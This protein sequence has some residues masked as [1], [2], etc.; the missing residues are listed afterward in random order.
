M[1]ENI[2]N[3][4]HRRMAIDK[5]LFFVIADVGINLVEKIADA[6]PDR[7]LNVGIAEQNMIGVCAGL[8]NGGYHPVTYTISNFSTHRCLEQVRDEVGLH[9]YPIIML[10]TTT[11]F[12][13]ST[14]GPTHHAI[15]DWGAMRIVPHL[16][17][18]CPSSVPYAA[19]LFDDLVDRKVAAYVRIPKGSFPNP[20]SAEPVVHLPGAQSDVLVVTYGGLASA[21]VQAQKLDPRLALMVFNRLKPVD[22]ES[23][24]EVWSR[25][26]RIIVVEDHFAEIGLF[27]TA[28][29]VAV[30]QRLS[31]QIESRAPVRYHREVGDTPE[32]FWKKFGGDPKTLLREVFGEALAPVG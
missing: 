24:A 25:Y 8:A 12:D 5:S 27:A 3:A 17:I 31:V 16:E 11:G 20:A 28:C 23:V 10:G 14:L 19:K 2:I 32:H 7:F 18:H 4:L 30:T 1:R 15:D 13:N 22:E 9:D 29:Q 21:Y 6:Y 26:S